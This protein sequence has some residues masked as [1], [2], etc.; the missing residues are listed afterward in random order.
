MCFDYFY[1]M[2]I[3]V[4]A[5]LIFLSLVQFSCHEKTENTQKQ[6][7]TLSQKDLA[8]P[9]IKALTDK[10]QGDPDNPENYFLRSNVFLANN[11]IKAAFSDLSMAIALDSSNNKYYFAMADL[12]LK[13]GSAD[14]ALVAF[15]QILHRDPKNK[16]ALIKLSKVYFFQKD[17]SQ[18]LIQLAK[19][20]ELDKNNAEEWFVRGLNLKEMGDTVRAVASFQKA[21]TIKQDF[22]DAYVQL[23]LLSSKKPSQI[24]AQYFDNAIHIDSSNVEAMY[25]KGKFFQDRG[26]AAYDKNNFTRANDNYEKAKAVYHELIAQNPQYQYSYFNLGFIYVRQDSLD[27]AYRMFDYAIRV[28]PSYAE[29]YYYRGLVSLEKRNK[30]QAKADFQQALTLKPDYQLAQKELNNLE[31]HK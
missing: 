8:D 3:F 15:N 16:Q 21:V 18:S 23:G 14:A 19:V 29:A 5:R 12:S 20:E 7:D 28:S 24:A 9:Q 10:I 22:Y 25:D 2:K 13:G 27:K 6:V 4:A 17:Y 30:D 11:N 31:S 1:R 26:D